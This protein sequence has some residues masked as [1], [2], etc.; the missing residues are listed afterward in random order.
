MIRSG[1][2]REQGIDDLAR[3]TSDEPQSCEMDCSLRGE[4]REEAIR[5]HQKAHVT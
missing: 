5:M 2:I 3:E 4:E 1:E